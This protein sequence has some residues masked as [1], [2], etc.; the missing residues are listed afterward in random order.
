MS[1]GWLMIIGQIIFIILV[2]VIDLKKE[3]YDTIEWG[4][5]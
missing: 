4:D 5:W 3:W 2:L 1:L